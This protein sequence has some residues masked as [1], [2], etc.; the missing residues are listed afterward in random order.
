MG[1]W[2]EIPLFIY[3]CKPLLMPTLGLVLFFNK[4]KIKKTRFYLLILALLFSFFG[5]VFLIFNTNFFLQGLLSF[6]IT[7]LIYILIF[8]KNVELKIN[9]KFIFVLFVF[10]AYYLFLIQLLSSYLDLLLFPVCVYGASLVIMGFG[11]FL[12]IPKH[13]YRSVL[14]GTLLFIFSDSILAVNHFMF[15]SNLKLAQVFVILLYVMAQY[16][17][18]KGLLEKRSD[19]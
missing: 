3:V 4:N 15:D 18:V 12:R 13:G 17:I 9:F 11:A 19:V 6:L 7:H 5:D 8:Y 10:L 1:G 16:F 2:L 14:L